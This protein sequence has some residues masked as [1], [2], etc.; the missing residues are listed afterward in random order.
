MVDVIMFILS[1]A[2]LFF[3]IFPLWY[4]LDDEGT[5]DE[6]LSE[7]NLITN[8]EKKFFND[9]TV[10]KP[11]SISEDVLTWLQEIKSIF[12]SQPRKGNEILSIYPTLNQYFKVVE[13]FLETLFYWHRT[14]C[15]LWSVL[16]GVFTELSTKV[17]F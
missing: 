14:T 1:E 9:I 12:N 4:V 17:Q 2:L 13:Y 10:L 6:V 11:Q 3:N 15:K 8:L 7:E 5:F 16:S